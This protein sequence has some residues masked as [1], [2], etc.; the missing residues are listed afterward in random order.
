MRG[1]RRCRPAVLY[2]D[3]HFPQRRDGLPRGCPP[4][5]LPQVGSFH[6]PSPARSNP[7]PPFRSSSTPPTC[8]TPTPPL[9]H[10]APPAHIP[11]IPL[12]VRPRGPA[13][14]SDGLG[15]DRGDSSS[16]ASA[17]PALP[18]D[19]RPPDSSKG[20]ECRT[21]DPDFGR[22]L[23]G[24]FDSKAASTLM[25]PDLSFDSVTLGPQAMASVPPPAPAPQGDPPPTRAASQRRRRTG[26][27]S[28]SVDVL[29]T[30]PGSAH[31][32]GSL[33][34]SW[35][36]PQPLP[37]SPSRSPLL[38]PIRYGLGQQ[39]K[40][41]TDEERALD[42]EM[43]HAFLCPV[44]WLNSDSDNESSPPGSPALPSS[45]STRS[46]PA[47]A[48]ERRPP[49]REG[50][51]RWS[52]VRNVTKWLTSS[53]PKPADFHAFVT[54]AGVPLQ[55]RRQ[56]GEGAEAVV[57]RCADAEGREWAV[58]R[59]N[60]QRPE[61]AL[62]V[63]REIEVLGHLRHSNVVHYLGSESVRQAGGATHTYIATELASGNLEAMLA[64][65]ARRTAYYS[66]RELLRVSH[67]VLSALTYL[68]SRGWVH[69]ALHPGHICW[70]EEPH[71]PDKGAKGCY[72]L[73]GF[74]ACMGSLTGP[75][76]LP[77]PNPQWPGYLAP[78]L[79]GAARDTA[80]EKVDMWAF[81]CVLYNLC[82]LRPAFPKG[83]HKAVFGNRQTIP[84]P[85]VPEYSEQVVKLLHWCLD[86]DPVSRSD[87]HT[88][89]HMVD[90][91]HTPFK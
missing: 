27:W 44:V 35:P 39:P 43:L 34:E 14:P 29:S 64:E 84:L 42:F 38:P 16:T 45:S 50:K 37:K 70:C 26:S 81:G 71:G 5:A 30:G 20:S 82:Y 31:G 74:K 61:P 88:A 60:I 56:L 22:F 57:L 62:A 83:M 76:P 3:L 53:G 86:L 85:A 33:N 32:G 90:Q 79:G 78:E 4:D 77:P 54:I 67:D 87:A 69:R 21:P 25:D 13:K 51:K 7:T 41:L 1:R 65:R 23:S 2:R 6:Q 75:F 55:F 11:P 36:P 58:K 72:K 40:K 91:L 9:I 49:N 59:Y 12:G 47:S 19:A 68:H 15:E 52:T 89:L 8:S 63:R 17:S 66:E 46:H 48:P 80:D 73:R 28:S 18:W 10:S 24:S